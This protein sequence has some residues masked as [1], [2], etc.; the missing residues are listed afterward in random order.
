MQVAERGGVDNC[1]K[2][3]MELINP[4]SHSCCI[5]IGQLKEKP[6]ESYQKDLKN[7]SKTN[8]NLCPSGDVTTRS[9]AM[10]A[11]PL[12]NLDLNFGIEKSFSN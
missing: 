3:N 1:R 7:L 8:P 6:S 11:S 5:L 4:V 10:V 9:I 2:A 12:A